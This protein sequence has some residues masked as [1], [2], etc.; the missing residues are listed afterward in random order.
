VSRFT[1]VPASEYL[2]NR[3]AAVA[4]CGGSWKLGRRKGASAQRT[5]G[6]GILFAIVYRGY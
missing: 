6:M 2:L 5:V 4:A 1:A 3:G